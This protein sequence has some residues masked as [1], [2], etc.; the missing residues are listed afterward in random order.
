MTKHNKHTKKNPVTNCNGILILNLRYI[1]PELGKL[2]ANHIELLPVFLVV[3]QV[4]F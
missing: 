3:Y 2:L 4:A 1:N